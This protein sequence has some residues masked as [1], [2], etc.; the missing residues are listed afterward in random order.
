MLGLID[1]R[2]RQAFLDHKNEPFVRR[3]IIMFGN[4]G[5]L[6]PVFDSPMFVKNPSQDTMSNNG[7]AAYKHFQEVYKLSVIQRQSG[8]SKE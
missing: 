6:P 4:F 8:E 1:T 7:L 2:L 5:Q 3:S